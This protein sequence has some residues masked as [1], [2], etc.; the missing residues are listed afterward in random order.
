[1]LLS[2]HST[3]IRELP[4]CL[5]SSGDKA[6]DKELTS[7]RERRAHKQQQRNITLDTNNETEEGLGD[8]GTPEDPGFHHASF[9]SGSTDHPLS[10]SLGSP[11]ER[12]PYLF[13]TCLVLL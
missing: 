8:S 10:L 11:R 4:V 6:A 5:L 1:M 13:L 2:S 9:T 7:L 12:H 3:R